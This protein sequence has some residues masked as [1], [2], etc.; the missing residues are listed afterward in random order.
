MSKVIDKIVKEFKSWTW[1]HLFIFVLTFMAYAAFHGCRKS[2]SNIKD[3]LA[4]NF[5]PNTTYFPYDTW[6]KETTFANKD[7]ADVFLG[8]LDSLFLFAYAFGLFVNG[9]LGDRLN[10]RYFLAFGMCGSAIVTFIFGYLGAAY[11]VRKTI[12]YQILQF[13]NGLLQSIGWPAVVSIMG[14]WFSK[15]SAG[16][17]FGIWSANASVGNIIGSVVLAQVLNYGYEYGMLLNSLILF[18]VGL[19]VLFCLVVHP[20]EIGLENPD[21]QERVETLGQEDNDPLLP[22]NKVAVQQPKPISFIQA[23]LIPGVIP[24]SLAYACLKLVNYSFFFWLPTYLSQG[25][26]W[27]DD[28]SVEFSNFYDIGGIFG[29]I[30]A[31]IVSDCIG[32]RSPVVGIMLAFSVGTILC[33]N[34]F[35]GVYNVTVAILFI[36]GFMIGGPANT[37]STAITADLGKHEK[38]MGNAEALATVTGIVDGTGSVGAAIGQ[39]LVGVINKK[40]GWQYVFY[41]LIVMTGLSIVC[42]IPMLINE[43]KYLF[44]RRPDPRRYSPIGSQAEPEEVRS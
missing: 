13:F 3:E 39:Y 18:C 30:I 8:E 16:F 40:A 36:N 6:Q 31:G 29:G 25:L 21:Q 27:K 23:V 12:F 41:F 42:I 43:L 4:E 20:N 19:I 2:F 34:Y 9:A 44:R 5:T 14:N 15:S 17:V 24:Y 26:H 22:S 1:H 33:F 7:D 32:V 11:H 28:K 37:I 38:I 35:S 10:L